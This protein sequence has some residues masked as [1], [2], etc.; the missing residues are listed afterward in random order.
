[1]MSRFFSFVVV[2]AACASL[3]SVAN[4]QTLS[5]RLHENVVSQAQAAAAPSAAS[6]GQILKRQEPALGASEPVDPQA[7][8][9][10]P[11]VSE[12][13]PVSA[14]SLPDGIA[15]AGAALL[16]ALVIILLLMLVSSFQH[17][18]DAR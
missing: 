13:M 16:G 3:V 14:F 17:K 7:S 8:V 6:L 5:E 4:A 18:E 9:G 2:L 10:A 12:G 1:M 11:V 15:A